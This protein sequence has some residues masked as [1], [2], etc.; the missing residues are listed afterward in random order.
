M[1]RTTPVHECCTWYTRFIWYCS[2]LQWL[3]EYSTA[4]SPSKLWRSD[5]MPTILVVV[6][7]HTGWRR[8]KFPA[9]LV[10]HH[11]GWWINRVGTVFHQWLSHIMIA[12]NSTLTHFLASNVFLAHFE[13]ATSRT[14]QRQHRSVGEP[15]EREHYSL[16][17]W[18]YLQDSACC[19]LSRF[20]VQEN[21]CIISGCKTRYL[22]VKDYLSLYT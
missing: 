15:S 1:T 16:Y 12:C 3:L 6:T 18:V 10:M 11:T 22:Y 5:E 2:L 8:K 9:D 13:S 19:K 17:C 20:G 4:W 7:C 21:L 14:L